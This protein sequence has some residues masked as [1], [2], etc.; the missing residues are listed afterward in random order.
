MKTT[1]ATCSK[2]KHQVQLQLFY[3]WKWQLV[4][5][6][7]DLFV[8][9]SAQNLQLSGVSTAEQSTSHFTISSASIGFHVLNQ[10]SAFS[11][12]DSLCN[13]RGLVSTLTIARW[14]CDRQ[15][16]NWWKNEKRKK[17]RTVLGNCDLP[18]FSH[19]LMRCCLGTEIKSFLSTPFPLLYIHSEFDTLQEHLLM[20]LSLPTAEPDHTRFPHRRCSCSTGQGRTKTRL[21][22]IAWPRCAAS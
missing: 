17:P 22:H 8:V 1:K 14:S 5:S 20:L 18:L 10:I 15:T 2:I 7:H 11:S 4:N 16:L 9:P 19:S 3:D 6:C 13:C 12:V 21:L